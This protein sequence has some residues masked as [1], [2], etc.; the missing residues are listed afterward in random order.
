MALKNISKYKILIDSSS[1]KTQGLRVGDIVRRQYFD[2]P[3]LIYSLMV[4]LD[5]GTDV[6]GGNESAYFIGGLLEGDEPKTGELL[7][8]VRITSMFDA[9]RSGALYLTAS[10]SDSPF[11]DIVDFA[12]GEKSI[13]Y[14]SGIDNYNEK[15]SK[16]YTCV[17]LPKVIAEYTE[18]QTEANRIV[19]LI[20]NSGTKNCEYIGLKQ[21]LSYVPNYPDKIVVSFKIKGSKESLNNFVELSYTNG[22]QSE[23]KYTFDI[24]KEWRYIFIIFSID[25]PVQYQRSLIIDASKLLQNE[26]EWCEIAD[27]NVS[28]LSVLSNFS[29]HSKARIGKISGIV[30]PIF[31]VLDGYGA[32]FQN[33]YATK[34]VNIA[35]TL[36]AGDENGF[37]STF[38][39]GKIH[40]NVIINSTECDM[41]G[42]MVPVNEISPT[43]VGLVYSFVNAGGINIQTESWLNDH[44][45][46]EYCFSF[47]AKNKIT[48]ILKLYQNDNYVGELVIDSPQWKRYYVSFLLTGRINKKLTIEFEFTEQG[49]LFSCPQL[50]SG[51]TPS[52][53]QPT[54]GTLSYVED[55][56]AWFS[57]GGIGGTIQNP[58]LKLN[59]DGSIS[60]RD[61]SFVIKP[62]GTGYFA[63]GRF[64][65]SKDTITLK[66]VN[67]KFE[68]LSEE[69]QEVLRP[70]VVEISSKS[71]FSIKN[72][73]N[74][75]DATAKLTRNGKELD[76]LGMNYTYSWSLWNAQGTAIKKVFSGKSITVSK[77]D[78]T[79]KGVLTCEVTEK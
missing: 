32:Y 48:S 75:V 46:K 14:P 4:V 15:P 44:H 69:S 25:N 34:N 1:K 51:K 26:N 35:G 59:E 33:I 23:G 36:T 2:N 17:G 49:T 10:D 5:T 8:F 66:D 18:S 68:E 37:S 73:F 50:E 56:G 39:V 53:Y 29:D 71:G 31:G 74:D 19:K 65:W 22:N 16:H 61:N 77:Y 7:D 9:G 76:I 63:S 20:C 11:M 28:E 64:E 57:K 58:L 24:T 40:K 30:D 72:N 38:Y 41:I 60:S 45:N 6:I 47:W 13:C 62:D 21:N 3:N 79:E 12:G 27:L 55:Y 70:I 67:I 42:I 52:Q 78:V 54:D 43:S